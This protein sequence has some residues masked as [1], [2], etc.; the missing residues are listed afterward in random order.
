[1]PRVKNI[2]ICGHDEMIILSYTRGVG[3]GGSSK[4]IRQKKCSS[5]ALIVHFRVN[6]CFCVKRVFV[7]NL[8]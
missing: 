8:S 6:L 7:Q 2:M 1:M 5:Q 3:G 4:V